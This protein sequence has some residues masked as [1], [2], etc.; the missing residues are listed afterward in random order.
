VAIDVPRSDGSLAAG[1]VSRED[2]AGV[3]AR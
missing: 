2:L 1:T 3:L